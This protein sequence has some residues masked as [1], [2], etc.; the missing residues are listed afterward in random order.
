MPVLDLTE[1]KEILMFVFSLLEFTFT[2][3][4]NSEKDDNYPE[5]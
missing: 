4:D 1:N 3:R 5:S 2:D